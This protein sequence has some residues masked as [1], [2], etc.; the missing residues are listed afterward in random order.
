W[1][2]KSNQIGVMGFSAG[3]HLASTLSVHYNDVKIADKDLSLRPDFSILIYPVI[4]ILES[5]KSG[6]ARNLLGAATQSQEVLTYFSSERNVNENTPP[7]FL[8]HAVDDKG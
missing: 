3:G 1:N 4:S 8:V 6:S 7:A 5:P 2:L